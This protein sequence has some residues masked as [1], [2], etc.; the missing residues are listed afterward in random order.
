MQKLN[1]A[2]DAFLAVEGDN[3]PGAEVSSEKSSLD[4]DKEFLATLL[5]EVE[6]QVNK[7]VPSCNLD[8][9]PHEPNNTVVLYEEL[10][11]V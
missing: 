9:L 1:K 8:G 6:E 11:H 3:T 5:N 4:N 10:K 2:Y 7:S